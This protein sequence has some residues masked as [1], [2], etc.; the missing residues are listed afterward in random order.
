MNDVSKYVEYYLREI[1]QIDFD[2][3]SEKESQE[4][5]LYILKELEKPTRAAGIHR[6]DEWNYGW[7]ESLNENSFIPKYFG[8]YPVIRLNQQFV[9]SENVNLEYQS[10]CGIQKYIFAKYLKEF[11]NMYEFGCGTGHNLIR[12][13]GVNDKANLYGLDWASSGVQ[14]VNKLATVLD[15]VYGIQFD[16]FSPNY[17]VNIKDNSAIITVASME[18]LGFNYFNFVNYL[19]SK[20]PKL[21]LHIEPI[22]EMLDES[23]L[24]D[25]L[26]TKYAEKREYLNGYL[27]Y[28]K[29]CDKVK[30][31]ECSR[32]YVGSLFIDGYSIIAWTLN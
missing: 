6:K 23:N 14:S 15:G 11:D 32:S 5:I 21:V 8:K 3:V 30:I 29:K 24:L 16:M 27:T 17:N 22:N 25:F 7:Q 9:K 19:I 1:Q 4:W 12:V 13:R 20:K 26:S 2:P 31:I 18:Q 10:L 28:L